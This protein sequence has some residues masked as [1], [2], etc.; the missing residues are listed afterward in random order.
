[1]RHD[2]I[3]NTLAYFI[4]EAKCKDVRV[5]QMPSSRSHRY[6]RNMRKQRKACTKKE[7][8]IFTI[9]LSK[10]ILII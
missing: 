7:S 4:R 3:R 2:N 8:D 6:I 9:I 1:M 10:F 5:E